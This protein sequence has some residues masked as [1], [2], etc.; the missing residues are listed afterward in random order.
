MARTRPAG[1]SIS[2]I[3]SHRM[4][5]TA[6]TSFL[7][8]RLPGPVDWLAPGS[9]APGDA[10]IVLSMHEP[11]DATPRIIRE[12]TSRRSR[13][14]LVYDSAHPH[15][16]LLDAAA[17]LRVWSVFDMRQDARG[18]VERA[19]DAAAGTGWSLD[20]VTQSW[21][22]A[23]ETREDG[24]SPREQQVIEQYFSHPDANPASVA[25]DLGISVNTVRV[26]LA[27]VR[28][29]LVGRHTRNR[30]AL[31]AALIDRGWLD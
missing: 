24:L 14:V 27:N 28:R 3:T 29:K 7:A 12:S 6:L 13:V 9:G 20:N 1:P 21:N 31:R 16:E 15:R 23:L 26:H 25:D 19:R 5:G 18:L 30:E 22:R 10:S 11:A 2:V 8:S 17:L 4:A